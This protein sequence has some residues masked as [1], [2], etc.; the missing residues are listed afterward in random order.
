MTAFRIVAAETPDDIAA[1][2]TLFTTYAASLGVDLSYQGFE[3]ELAEL[4]GTY[5]PPDGALLLARGADGTPLGCVALRPIAP[6]GCCEMKRLYVAPEARGSGLGRALAEAAIAAAA[7][8]G[9]REMRLDSLPSMQAARAL[10]AA[11]GFTPIAPYY[12]TPVA[13]T[14]FLAKRLS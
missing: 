3:R 1:I 12:E 11:L 9:H 14:A 8:M 7:R 2:R 10:Y 13:G 6:E 5:A 4:P